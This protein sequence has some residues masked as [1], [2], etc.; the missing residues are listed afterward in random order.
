MKGTSTK[1]LVCHAH[2]VPDRDTPVAT[3]SHQICFEE[4]I[5]DI[6]VAAV[7]SV[8][9]VDN[10]VKSCRKTLSKMSESNFKKKIALAI[11]KINGQNPNKSKFFV[12]FNF[13]NDLL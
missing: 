8:V 1:T 3:F 10:V 4:V 11:Q 13:K 5:D 6:V 9:E 12:S 2:E 7:E